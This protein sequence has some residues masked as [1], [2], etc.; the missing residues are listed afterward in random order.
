MWRLVVLLILIAGILPGCS[1]SPALSEPETV[2]VTY[3]EAMEAKDEVAVAACFVRE[4]WARILSE[5][6]DAYSQIDSIVVSGLTTALMSESMTAATVLAE[7]D[8]Q[9]TTGGKVESSHQ[10]EMVDLIN[11]DGGWLIEGIMIVPESGVEGHSEEFTLDDEVMHLV[12]ATFFSDAHGGFNSGKGTWCDS[13]GGEPGHYFPTALGIWQDHTLVLNY[14]ELDSLGNPRVD[15]GTLGT[16]ADTAAIERHAVWMGLIVNAAGSFTPVP[17]GTSDRA[18]AAPLAGDVALYLREVSES[19]G[20]FNG[21][22]APGGTYT[23]VIGADGVSFAAY[24]RTG[25]V[26]YAGFNEEYP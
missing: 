26:W 9:V 22:P 10:R 16:P 17:G 8:W 20:V 24:P 7:Y 3:L 2:V 21:V 11:L 23:W 14:D 6:K 12:V 1:G 18:A 4:E 25:G 15:E 5:G 13:A 19:G